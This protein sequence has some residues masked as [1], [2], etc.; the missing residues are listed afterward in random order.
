MIYDWKME[1]YWRLPVFLQEALL[2]GYARK[3][4]RLYYGPA[5]EEWR[6]RF[7]AWRSWSRTDIE[8]WQNQQLQ[9]LVDLAATKVPHYREMWRGVDWKSVRCAAALP[10]LPCLEK[11]S[12]RQKE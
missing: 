9:F 7:Q 4:D 8:T 5:F 1:L 3:L 12:I 6:Q 10:I 2:S 11:Q